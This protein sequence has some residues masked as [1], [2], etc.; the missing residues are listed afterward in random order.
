MTR[1]CLFYGASI[2]GVMLIFFDG[3]VNYSEALAVIGLYSVYILIMYFNGRIEKWVKEKL[4]SKEKSGS[5]Q[6]AL[7]LFGKLYLK[8]EKKNKRELTKGMIAL[9]STPNSSW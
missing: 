5:F 1:D 7:N 3:I 2:L 9:C 4:L 8:N 6:P